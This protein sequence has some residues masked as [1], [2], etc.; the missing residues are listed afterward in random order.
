MKAEEE[1]LYKAGGEALIAGLGIGDALRFLQLVR[2]GKGDY[3]KERRERMDRGEL[4]ALA[5]EL[6]A[7]VR[8]RSQDEANQPE[9]VGQVA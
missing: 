9:F 5:E 3:T 6:H 7:R 8:A 4:D 1:K 2:P